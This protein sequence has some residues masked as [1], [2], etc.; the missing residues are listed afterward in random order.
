MRQGAPAPIALTVLALI[1]WRMPGVSVRRISYELSC[2]IPWLYSIARRY[3]MPSKPRENLGDRYELEKM[4]VGETKIW[5]CDEKKVS[6][7]QRLIIAAGR[8]HKVKVSTKV[9]HEKDRHG[10]YYTVAER[11]V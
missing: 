6:D 5:L 8:S 4:E 3:K 10:T 2:S 1:L 11:R 7:Q 9:F